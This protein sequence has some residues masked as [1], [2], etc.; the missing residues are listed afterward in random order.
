MAQAEGKLG[1]KNRKVSYVDGNCRPSRARLFVHYNSPNVAFFKWWSSKEEELAWPQ[2]PW[3]TQPNF[4]RHPLPHVWV[5]W[6]IFGMGG[7]RSEL[8]LQFC[9]CA[10]WTQINHFTSVLLSSFYPLLDTLPILLQHLSL[11]L[12]LCHAYCWGAVLSGA[13]IVL[14]NSKEI[15]HQGS[16]VISELS[17]NKILQ[18]I[19][20]SCLL[21]YYLV[22]CS[23]FNMGKYQLW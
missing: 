8:R 15:L 9:Y 18:K 17:V 3:S 12:C 11:I 21:F 20:S 1:E 10:L 23:I 13:A 7:R 19:E 5:G 6:V 14:M 16:P 22:F 2:E 4:H